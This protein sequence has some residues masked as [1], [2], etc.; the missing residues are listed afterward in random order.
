MIDNISNRHDDAEHPEEF[1]LTAA[2]K[3]ALEKLPRERFPSEALEDRVVGALRDRGILAQ[4]RG[5]VIEVTP[6]RIVAALAACLVLVAGGFAFGQ[7]VSTRQVA[8]DE[9]ILPEISNISVAAQVQQAGSA[10]V[11]ALE[12]FADLPDSI[13]AD[14]ADQGR[15]VA[16]AT[17]C[18][19]AD[20]VT[21]LV[22]RSELAVQLSATLDTD[23][24][25]RTADER[26]DIAVQ[27]NSV[28]EF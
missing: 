28:I 25:G 11:I 27:R 7:W 10:Y 17:L 21:R 2:E 19:A 20:K 16:L 9:L 8:D 4:P 18:T 6:G 23:L 26:G 12:R 22:P 13:N 1:K 3:E 24:S 14:Q 15:E 5:R